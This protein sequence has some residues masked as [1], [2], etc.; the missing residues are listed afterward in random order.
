MKTFYKQLRLAFPL[1]PIPPSGALFTAPRSSAESEGIKARSALAGKNWMNVEGE[2]LPPVLNLLSDIAF[3]YYLP[4]FLEA[5]SCARATTNP[6]VYL[7]VEALNPYS[8]GRIISWLDKKFSQLT[9]DQRK[10]V[11]A[12][13][14]N[15]A[16]RSPKPY[17]GP[18]YKALRAYWHD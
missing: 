14:D 4:A 7:T 12:F 15:I 16:R 3:C 5:A 6:L 1:E 11:S 18:S 2:K 13:L 10:V 8:E 17:A 9:P